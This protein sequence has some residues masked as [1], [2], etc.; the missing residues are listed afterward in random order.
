[1]S[2]QGRCLP[3]MWSTY[4]AGVRLLQAQSWHPQRQL[5]HELML[6]SM[7]GRTWTGSKAGRAPASL[8]VHLE[9][10]TIAHTTVAQ[11]RLQRGPGMSWEHTEAL[12]PGSLR[13]SSPDVSEMTQTE[14][15]AHL[16]KIQHFKVALVIQHQTL[17]MNPERK[18]MSESS[19]SVLFCLVWKWDSPVSKTQL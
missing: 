17:K 2:Q 8:L 6:G 7:F 11:V 9:T 10:R 1:M 3:C 5:H 14:K 4:F 15:A 16:F 18:L 12:L 19:P 13:D